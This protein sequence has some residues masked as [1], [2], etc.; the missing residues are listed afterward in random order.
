[1]AK[2]MAGV[3]FATHLRDQAV[4]TAAGTDGILA[5]E[6]VGDPLEHRARVV[7]EAAHQPR[8]HGVGDAERIE[9]GAQL[10]E[11]LLR[12]GVEVI[13][14]HRRVADDGLR[15]RMFAVEDAQR[16]AFEAALA[17]LIQRVEVLRENSPA[18]AR[19]RPCATRTCRAS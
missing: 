14:E 15:G 2:P 19:D 4:V 7:V 9:A 6:R 17:V 1:M 3:G 10:R 11:M 8:I 13:G 18:A 16:V 12:L 5:A